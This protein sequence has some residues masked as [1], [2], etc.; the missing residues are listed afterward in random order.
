[1]IC[2]LTPRPIA[3]AVTGAADR[4]VACAARAWPIAA[5]IS[6]KAIMYDATGPIAGASGLT[7]G[8][9]GEAASGF[10]TV[11]ATTGAWP[12]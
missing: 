5:A 6:G 11:G 8:T 9:V 4:S 7:V 2:A 10:V 12:R 3:A 1:M